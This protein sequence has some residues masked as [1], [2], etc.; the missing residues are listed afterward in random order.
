LVVLLHGVSASCQRP[1]RKDGFAERCGGC[2]RTAT[3]HRAAATALAV[4]GKPRRSVQM[5]LGRAP[6]CASPLRV[7]ARV[8][9]GPVRGRRLAGTAIGEHFGFLMCA[10]LISNGHRMGTLCAPRPP[11]PQ[12]CMVVGGLKQSPVFGVVWRRC[13]QEAEPL[14]S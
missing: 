10:P 5:R 13:T 4:Q 8:R 1:G 14:R 12:A 7:P 9:E 11:H 3:R 6:G 2:H